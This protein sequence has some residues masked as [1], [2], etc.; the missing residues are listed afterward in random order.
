MPAALL[1]VGN[2]KR[3][4]HEKTTDCICY[5]DGVRHERRVC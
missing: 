5:R 1:A 4:D 3:A 2:L